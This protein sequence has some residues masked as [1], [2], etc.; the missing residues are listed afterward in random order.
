MMVTDD[1]AR[2]MKLKNIGIGYSVIGFA[3]PEVMMGDL[4]EVPLWASGKQRSL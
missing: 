2:K 1:N 4:Y 3:S